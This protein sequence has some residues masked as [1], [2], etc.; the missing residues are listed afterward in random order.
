[1]EFRQYQ[2]GDLP[3]LISDEGIKLIATDKHVDDKLSWTLYDK[4]IVACGGFAIMWTGVYEAW[5]HV[6]SYLTFLHYKI[7]LIK[8]FRSE[9]DK[10]NFHRLQAVVDVAAINHERFMHLLG[11]EEEGIL[12][13]YDWKKHDHI[14][15]ARLK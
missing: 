7:C 12:K 1:M 2:R 10:L 14:M 4:Q 13:Q 9:I 5:L 8:K 11:F 6:D 3:S 15:Y